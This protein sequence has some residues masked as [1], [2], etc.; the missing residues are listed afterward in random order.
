MA[1]PP[2]QLIGHWA[3]RTIALITSGSCNGP[4]YRG[5]LPQDQARICPQTIRNSTLEKCEPRSPKGIHTR[6]L[7][8]SSLFSNKLRSSLAKPKTT[9]LSLARGLVFSQVHFVFSKLQRV[10]R[11]SIKL[12]YCN[13]HR[14]LLGRSG[15]KN[16]IFCIL[17]RILHCLLPD[18]LAGL[19]INA[20]SGNACNLG[21][22]P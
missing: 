2:R 7:W 1:R 5:E 11:P 6:P 17:L 21:W 13:L 12:V 20:A 16:N 15:L 3:P 22:A 14:G 19:S 9:F 4:S 18:M 10:A 8:S